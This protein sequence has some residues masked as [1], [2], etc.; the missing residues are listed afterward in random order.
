VDGGARPLRPPTEVETAGWTCGE[1]GAGAARMPAPRQ[2]FMTKDEEKCRVPG[3]QLREGRA[4]LLSKKASVTS[5]A[6]RLPP[7]TAWPCA[8]AVIAT[9]AC[10]GYRET[11]EMLISAWIAREAKVDRGS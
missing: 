10:R 6:M 3:F 7:E 5:S 1:F 9:L 11:L 8:S 4:W 2:I